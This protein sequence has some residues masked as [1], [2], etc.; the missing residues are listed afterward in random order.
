[1]RLRRRAAELELEEILKNAGSSR[2][3]DGA[4]NR[5][6]IYRFIAAEKISFPRPGDVPCARGQ[7]IGVLRMGRPQ[8]CSRR[9]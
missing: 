6:S 5:R 8:W 1:M 4:K 2:E 9:P 7:P 3:G